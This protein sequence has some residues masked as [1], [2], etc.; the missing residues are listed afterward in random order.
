MSL[1]VT[2]EVREIVFLVNES[3]GVCVG[4]RVFV[5]DA[6]TVGETEVVTE[7][8][9]DSDRDSDSEVVFCESST[10]IDSVSDSEKEPQNSDVAFVVRA[11][12]EA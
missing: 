1:S 9:L 6:V 11:K 2:V 7:L 5:K 10:E 12:A 8:L 4:G 3:E